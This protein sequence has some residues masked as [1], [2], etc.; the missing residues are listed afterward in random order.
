MPPNLVC[1][2]FLDCDGDENPAFCER[3]RWLGEES[4]CQPDE[5]L[6]DDGRCVPA[7]SPCD[8]G[9]HILL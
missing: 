7:G 8:A 5:S 9:T 6:C 3:R 4:A 1:D 2:G